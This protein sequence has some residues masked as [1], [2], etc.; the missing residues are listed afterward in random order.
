MV[1]APDAVVFRPRKLIRVSTVACLSLC[2]LSL[3][4]WYALP[5]QLRAEF[6]PSQVATLVV[7]LLFLIGCVVV[8]ASSN[9]RADASG[10]RIRNGLGRHEIGWDAVH[11]FLL[12]PGDPWG[13]VLIKPD[14][15]PFE[16]DLDAEKRQLMGVQA[17][18]GEAAREAIRTL[19][20]MQRRFGSA[21]ARP[22]SG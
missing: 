22:G 5:P 2:L 3:F 9:V 17:G 12:R 16:V 11:K 10:L 18:D 14:D 7:I 8:I 1:E 20:A 15:R 4:G 19:T 21:P 13:L 6:L